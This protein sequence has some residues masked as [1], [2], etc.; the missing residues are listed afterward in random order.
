MTDEQYTGERKAVH[1]IPQISIRA[2]AD[3]EDVTQ[4]RGA[5][6]SSGALVRSADR[7]NKAPASSRLEAREVVVV[8]VSADDAALRV[9]DEAKRVEALLLGKLND[10]SRILKIAS[11][12]HSTAVTG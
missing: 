11:A 9:T 10:L 12:S 8:D 4:V 7:L 6:G 1:K 2:A 3:A 5:A